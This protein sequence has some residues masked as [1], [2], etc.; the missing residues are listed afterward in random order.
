MF[1][2]PLWSVNG[3]C[4]GVFTLFECLY[5]LVSKQTHYLLLIIVLLSFVVG[6][7]E[8]LWCFHFV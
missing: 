3:S 6:E 4:Y 2:F 5:E 1:F 8:L 7:W